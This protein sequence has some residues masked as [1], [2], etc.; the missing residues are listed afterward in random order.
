MISFRDGRAGRQ[1]LA[2]LSL[3]LL[4]AT[5]IPGQQPT[6]E[7]VTV[8]GVVSGWNTRVPLGAAGVSLVGGDRR[9]SSDAQGRFVLERV[10]LGAHV[11]REFLQSELGLPNGSIDDGIIPRPPIVRIYTKAFAERQALEPRPRMPVTC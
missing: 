8:T 5:P 11:L 4:S 1:G 10:R 3:A 7:G 2:A 6:N 9:T